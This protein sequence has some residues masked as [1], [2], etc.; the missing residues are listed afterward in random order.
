MSY[1]CLKLKLIVCLTG[2]IVAKVTCY[3]KKDDWNLFPNDWAFR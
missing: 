3:I 2:C 1:K